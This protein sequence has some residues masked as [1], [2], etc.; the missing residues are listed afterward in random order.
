MS[1][2]SAIASPALSPTLVTPLCALIQRLALSIFTSKQLSGHIYHLSGGNEYVF[3]TKTDEANTSHHSVEEDTERGGETWRKS[4]ASTCK[5][6][7]EER[8][9]KAAEGRK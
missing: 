2:A 4:C 8:R 3:Q 6:D 5:Q 7:K 9:D 1:L